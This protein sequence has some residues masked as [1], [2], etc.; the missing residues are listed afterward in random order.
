MD[1]LDA[2]IRAVQ[3]SRRIVA[4]TGAGISTESGIPDYR[5]PDGV[6][7]RRS[8]PT[9]ADFRTNPETRRHYWEQRR[10]NYPQLAAARPNAGHLALAA[11]E[12]AGRLDVVITQNIDG[13][14]QAAGNAPDHVIEL[15][16]TAHRVRCLDCGR[17]WPAEQIQARLATEPV[18]SCEVCGGPLRAAT[19]LFGEPLPQE[20]LA[21]ATDAARTCDLMLA[22]GSSLVVNPAAQLPLLA[23]RAGAILA[24]LNR[25]ETALDGSADLLLRGEAGPTLQAL[26]ATFVAD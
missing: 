2:L 13:L 26:A 11:M 24:I 22:I 17:G 25:T 1:H 5:G 6:W 19:I 8:P 9:L 21:R 3:E 16:G 12:R 4:L 10:L 23:K 15:H 14:H 18:P 7:A 20:A